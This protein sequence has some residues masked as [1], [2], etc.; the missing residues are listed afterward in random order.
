MPRIARFCTYFCK[1]YK[2][3]IHTIL[4]CALSLGHAYVAT[5]LRPFRDWQFLPIAEVQ[6][7]PRSVPARL[8]RSRRLVGNL[9]ATK[10]VAARF[11][12][13]FKLKPDCNWFGRRQVPARSA[14]SPRSVADQWLSLKRVGDW[15]AIDRRLIGDLNATSRRPVH[16][17]F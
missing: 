12:N 3:P 4:S 2:S 1:H 8:Q 16:N 15:S 7:G 10:S 11:L 17:L 13:M 9:A 6:Q 5:A 14:A